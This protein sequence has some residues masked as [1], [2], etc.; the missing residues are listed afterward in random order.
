MQYVAEE[1]ERAA[2]EALHD[3]ASTDIQRRLG[4]SCQTAGSA[5]VSVASA[6][7]AS[8]IVLNRTL[9]IGLRAP[10]TE[11]S[12]REIVETYRD[13]SVERYFL[14][15]H[16]DAQPSSIGQWLLDHG[17]EKARGWQKF[18]RGRDSVAGP[19]TDL[20]IREIG[21]EHGPEHAA[22]L[23]DAFDLGED[24]Q[25]W[26]SLMPTCDHWHVFMTFDGSDPAGTG[27]VYIDGKT[28]WMDFAA[29]SPRF[30]RRGSQSSLL[31]HRVQFALDHGCEQMFVCTGEAVPGDPQHSYSNIQKAGFKEDYVRANYAPIK[32]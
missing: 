21:A 17:H 2:L 6:L 29:T 24:A 26:M 7:P 23:C 8:A 4:I 18:S 12:L 20:S 3:V 30:R 15:L 25:P 16:P 11:D 22:I 27:A 14:Q 13:A 28:A 5:F 10:D 19:K 1:I 31:R 9:G 32:D